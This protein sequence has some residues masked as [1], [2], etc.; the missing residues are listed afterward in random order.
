MA[1]AKPPRLL[2]AFYSI[3][4]LSSADERMS[5]PLESHWGDLVDESHQDPVDATQWT[6]NLHSSSHKGISDPEDESFRIRTPADS[7]IGPIADSATALRHVRLFVDFMDIET[8][9]LWK[10]AAGTTQRKIAFADL[11]APLSKKQNSIPAAY[12]RG[13]TS[14]A[15]FFRKEDLPSEQQ[16]WDDIF[17]GTIGSPDPYGRQLDGMGGGISSLSKVCVVSKSDRPDADVEYTFVSLGVK[18]MDVDYSSNCGNMISAVGPYAVDTG[19]FPVADDADVVSVRIFNTNTGKI[20]RSTFPVVDGEAAAAGG[21]AIDGV[22]GTGARIRLDFIDPAGSRTGKL[23]PTGKSVDCFDDIPA[24]C[25]DVGNPCVFVRASDLGVPGNLAPDK[26]DAHPTLLSQLDS[27][28]RQA[29]V[30]MGL[31]GTTKEV[32]GSVPKIC[33]VSSPSDAYTSGMM[34]TPK[35]V[36]LVVRALSVGQP[37]KA[38]PITVAL[39]LATAARVS[40][41][42]VADVVSD[43]PV[44]PAGI[45]LGHA[46]GKLL[47]GAD[48]DPTGHVSCATVYRTARRIMEGRVFWKGVST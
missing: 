2:P 23:L 31:A 3:V 17:R 15:I 41:T 26:I 40:G 39:A 1:Q 30:K 5:S 19:L 16:Q 22:A 46:S 13:G 29:G 21:F 4:L 35:D 25:V 38:V 32:P 43:K 11:T 28:R 45:T 7:V 18:N 42:V 24:S 6:A 44:D 34:Q 20:I 12:Y 36:D 37:H 48:F 8:I 33:L 14:R 9:P 27:I 10:R 47:V